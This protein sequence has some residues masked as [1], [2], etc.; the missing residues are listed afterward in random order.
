[1]YLCQGTERHKTQDG[2]KEVTFCSPFF[3]S[4][5][6]GTM[7]R[8]DVPHNFCSL[9]LGLLRLSYDN[10]S[11]PL[12]ELQSFLSQIQAPYDFSA[13]DCYS[14]MVQVVKVPG[15]GSFGV[16]FYCIIYVSTSWCKVF[17]PSLKSSKTMS[18]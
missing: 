3:R 6:L 11:Q 4:L 18:F 9:A 5:I 13:T 10:F 14:F 2:V 16:F 15:K 8:S 7:L 1:M 12:C 17:L